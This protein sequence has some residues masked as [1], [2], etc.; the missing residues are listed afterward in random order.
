MENKYLCIYEVE[1]SSPNEGTVNYIY[2]QDFIQGWDWIEKNKGI[3]KII[4]Y[5][6]IIKSPMDRN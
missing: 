4:N 1:G 3:Y 5:A 2:F 6:E